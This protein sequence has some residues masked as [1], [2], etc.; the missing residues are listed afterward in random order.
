MTKTLSFGVLGRFIE[1]ETQL[2]GKK[3]KM[4]EGANENT[5]SKRRSQAVIAER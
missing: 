3:P 5:Y 1:R 4:T 2:R